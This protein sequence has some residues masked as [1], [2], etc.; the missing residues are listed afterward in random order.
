[1]MKLREVAL[2]LLLIGSVWASEDNTVDLFKRCGYCNQGNCVRDTFTV[3]QCMTY[4]DPCS[5][6]CHG[7]YFLSKTDSSNYYIKTYDDDDCIS[8]LNFTVHVYC[9]TCYYYEDSSLCPAFYLHCPSYWWAWCLGIG[10]SI[11]LVILVAMVVAFFIKQ[12][13]RQTAL[14]SGP[15]DEVSYEEANYQSIGTYQRPPSIN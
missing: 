3:G 10:V 8:K 15:I 2:V 7:S 14:E 4:C 5:N 9:D 1:M 13:Q 11:I 6:V 12:K